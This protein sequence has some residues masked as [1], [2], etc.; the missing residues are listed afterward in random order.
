MLKESFLQSNFIPDLDVAGQVDELDRGNVDPKV[1]EQI[2]EDF[3]DRVAE[4][5]FSDFEADVERKL[6]LQHVYRDVVPL[7]AEV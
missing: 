2:Q 7:L 3:A 6:R 5:S 1:F 4:I